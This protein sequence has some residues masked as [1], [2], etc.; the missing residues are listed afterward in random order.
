[1]NA[2]MPDDKE[3]SDCA[4]IGRGNHDSDKS[5]HAVHVFTAGASRAE[6]GE[7]AGRRRGLRVNMRSEVGEVGERKQHAGPG[8]QS[9]N[10]E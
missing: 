9:P 7:V 1:M 8:H 10:G 2:V 4:D 6:P 5:R 3:K